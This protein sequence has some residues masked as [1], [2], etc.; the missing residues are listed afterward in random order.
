MK[1][2]ADHNGRAW[3]RLSL[4]AQMSVCVYLCL[5]CPVLAAADPQPRVLAS[6][7]FTISE[8]ISYE[9]EHA[10]SLIRR[11]NNLS[12][13]VYMFLLLLGLWLYTDCRN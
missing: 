10:D 13:T 8:L 9:W 6:V 11:R 7:L 3:L 2:L 5:C 4:E 12:P 1:Q